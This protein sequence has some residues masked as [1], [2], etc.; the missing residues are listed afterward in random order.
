MLDMPEQTRLRQL[1]EDLRLRLLDLTKRNQLLNYGL[2]A[3]SKRFLQI[4]GVTL[5]GAHQRLAEEASVRIASLPDPDDIPSEERTEE[6]RSALERG[7]GTDVEYLTALEAIDATGR[8]DEA[9]MEKL[10][11]QL[12][13]RIRTELELPPRPSRK[14]LNRVD[15]A[16]S[17]AS[18]SQPNSS[19]A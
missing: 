9:A 19:N 7:R 2:K 18:A 6:F 1:Y 5:E 8:E 14:A 13:D 10:E 17:L 16:R 4:V 15:H 12:R 11:R 3:R